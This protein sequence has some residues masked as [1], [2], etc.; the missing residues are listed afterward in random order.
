MKKK[1]LL[2]VF[3][4]GFLFIFVSGNL[5]SEAD[6]VSTYGHISYVDKGATVIRQDKSEH[7]AVVNLP[8]APG[9]QIVTPKDGR[10]EIQF[11]NG[12]IIRLDKNTR[13]KVTTILAPTL[14]SKWK[15]TTLHL[16][17]G[18]LYTMIQSYNREMFQVITPNVAIDL[19]KR[20]ASTIELT[21]TG[22]TFIYPDKG[23]FKLLYGKDIESVKTAVAKAKKGYL[24]TTDHEIKF[25]KDKRDVDFIG[26]N[27]YIN[28]NF[29]DLHFGV[30]KVP[31]KIY[32]YSKGLVYWA[33]KWSSLYGEWVYDDLLGYVWKPGD[34]IFA[35]S[36]RPFFHANFANVNGKLFLVPQQPWGWVPAHMG[37][38]VWMKWGWT[39]VPGDAFTSGV[40]QYRSFRSPF[41][42]PTLDYY[43]CSLYGSY[44]LYYTY[45][46]RGYDRWRSEYRRV[47][48]RT[49]KKLSLKKL[50]AGVRTIIKKMDK[51]AVATIK[52]KLGTNRP[53]PMIHRDKLTPYV[54]S[55]SIKT[56][57]NLSRKTI[58]PPKSSR[59]NANLSKSA[60]T[61]GTKVNRTKM[62]PAKARFLKSQRALI[63]RNAKS[64]KNI[65]GFR[66]FNPDMRWAV[67]KGYRVGYSSKE[68]AVVCPKL[69]LNSRTMSQKTRT[70][71]RSSHGLSRS[72]GG[73]G[74]KYYSSSSNN[75]TSTSTNSSNS[76]ITASQSK[77]TR[78]GSTAGGPKAGMTAAKTKK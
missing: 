41:Y 70:A 60:V 22:E 56:P 24:I 58:T 76:T 67:R 27:E 31:K 15:V 51:T 11:G 64:R 63:Y 36:K 57:V 73:N 65:R 13:L 8:V 59:L 33:E 14:T 18:Q 34:E 39:W 35:Y 17:R 62:T 71:L 54:K 32:R 50:P 23:K 61:K 69:K 28:R 19:K 55:K 72:T 29:K 49:P 12:T 7:K 45:R 44:D 40:A 46:T 77:V 2:S 25:V 42:F 26:W 38:W 74:R 3:L 10:C 66:D 48:N 6:A 53:T 30:S 75:T 43:V 4:L 16:M 78:R 47:Y 37:T 20:S 21:D 5:Y 9:D 68:N 52:N 1:P